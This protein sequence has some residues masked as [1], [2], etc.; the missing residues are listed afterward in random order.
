MRLALSLP[1]S[2]VFLAANVNAGS[3]E[4]LVSDAGP[5]SFEYNFE[6]H[7]FDLRPHQVLDLQFDGSVY[8]SLSNA[9][10][11]LGFQVVILQP[12]NPPGT[13]GDYLLESMAPSTVLAPVSTGVDFTLVGQEQAGPLPFFIYQFNDQNQFVSVVT[14]GT[15]TLGTDP[16]PVPEPS[17]FWL[18]GLGLLA[19]CIWGIRWVSAPGYFCPSPL[20]SRRRSKSSLLR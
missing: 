3:I 4:G 5:S 13:P 16:P 17:S 8:Q 10:V 6:L 14:S 18:A 12:G 19:G 11:P 9:I 1:L 20:R 15:T 2:L 7:G